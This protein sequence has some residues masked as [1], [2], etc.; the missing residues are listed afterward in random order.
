MKKLDIKDSLKKNAFKKGSYS[1]ILIVIVIAI[2]FLVNMLVNQLPENVKAKDLSSQKLYTISNQSKSLLSSLDKDITIYQISETG[3][4]DSYINKLLDKYAALSK[5]INVQTLDP[6]LSLG[7][8]TTYNASDLPDNSLTFVSGDRYKTVSYDDIY[9]ADYSNYYYSGSTSYNYDGEGEITSAINYVTT[10]NL[11]IIY[12][13]TGHGEQTFADTI[14]K[15]VTKQNISTESLNLLNSDVPED[16]SILAILSPTKDCSADEASKIINYLK[17]GG[18]ALIIMQYN[19]EDITNFNSVLNEYCVSLDTGYVVETDKNYYVDNGYY[20][21]PNAEDSDITSSINDDG[22][23][24]MV[25]FSSAIKKSDVVRDTFTITDLLTTTSDSYLDTDYGQDGNY[26]KSSDDTSG[27]FSV[28]VSIE[29]SNDD[30]SKTQIVLYSCYNMFLSQ[31]IDQYTLGNTDLIT[32]SLSWMSNNNTL[33]SIPTKSLSTA[34]NTV[35]ASRA[36]MY[37]GIFCIIVPL[38]IIAAGF[39]IWYKRRKA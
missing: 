36:N 7:L 35:S 16:C 23:Y 37:T 3:S 31:I 39:V 21:L 32:N 9:E 28:G 8:L 20:L 12:A 30:G 33:I 34:Y 38:V 6:E 2:A 1:A 5:H 18:K 11:P 17:N 4:E 29:E 15:A 13:V 10:E 25:P 22:M 19:G 27:S 24:V 26:G 14:S